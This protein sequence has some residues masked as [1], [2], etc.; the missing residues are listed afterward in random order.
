MVNYGKSRKITRLS[1]VR[2][3]DLQW[4]LIGDDQVDSI[5]IVH[6]G[7]KMQETR[8][9]GA[10]IANWTPPP[11]PSGATLTGRYA[12][13]QPLTA[14][15]HAA[16]LFKANSAS[17]AIWDWLPYG[18]FA[19]AASYHRWM[20]DITAGNDPLFYAIRNLDSGHWEGVASYLRI[21]PEMGSIELGHIN[22]SADLQQTRAATEAMF[23]MMQWAFEAGY[24]RFEWKCNALNIGSRRAAQRLGLSYEGIFRQAGVVKGHNRDTAWF[25]AID[26]EWPALK[27]AFA[28]WLAPENFDTNGRQRE[29]LGDLTGLVRVADDQGLARA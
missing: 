16:E 24:R 28:A 20:R 15:T 7:A 25:A 2:F 11:R 29:K 27:E 18:P 8:D 21:A 4:R 10:A 5:R 22:F 17:D 19:S 23:L 14:D 12:L 1:R 6:K 3:R 13:L 26:S 9:I